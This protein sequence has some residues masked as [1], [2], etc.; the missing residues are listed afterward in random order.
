MSVSSV[1]NRFMEYV[2]FDTQAV[3]DTG[4]VPS[5][6]GQ[7]VFARHL[8]DEL[9]RI[10]LADVTCDEHAY[11]I[12]TLPSN[13]SRK[14]PTVALIAHLDTAYE[15]SGKNVKPRIVTYDGGDIVLDADLAGKI[16]VV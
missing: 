7:L 2:T 3:R 14:I 4:R 5:S 1:V 9:R 11:V 10:G 8:A 15:T 16:A 6:E 12:A 13:S